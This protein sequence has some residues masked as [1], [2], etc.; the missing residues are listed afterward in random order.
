MKEVNLN[1]KVS[2]AKRRKMPWFLFIV[3]L[4]SIIT[5]LSFLIVYNDVF[6]LD[7]IKAQN[8][9]LGFSAGIFFAILLI[10]FSLSKLLKSAT[11]L[12]SDLEN[13]Y[14][15]IGRKKHEVI[16]IEEIKK[17]DHKLK[18]GKK[19]KVTYGTV[20]IRAKKRFKI[21]GV[22]YPDQVEKDLLKL[23]E[24]YQAYLLGI[25]KGLEI[26]QQANHYNIS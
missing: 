17:V 9:I 5:I 26:E 18:N 24:R 15:N 4:A 8:L 19:A 13:I 2:L 6:K 16:P 7:D 1:K 23:V 10:F 12:E 14:Y 22:K 3:F 20:I 25:K 11:I 21:R